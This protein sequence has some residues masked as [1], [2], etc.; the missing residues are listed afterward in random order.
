MKMA[1]VGRRNTGK[2]TFVNT[3]ARAERRLR[4]DGF[5][6]GRPGVRPAVGEVL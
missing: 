3:L 2:S 5:F 1:I 6:A 4:T